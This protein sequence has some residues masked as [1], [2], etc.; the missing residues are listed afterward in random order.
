MNKFTFTLV[1]LT[2]FFS[3]Q[4]SHAA[5]PATPGLSVPGLSSPATNTAPIVPQSPTTSGA[6][7]VVAQATAPVA[8]AASSGPGTAAT[9]G[10]DALSHAEF[11]GA[12]P[13]LGQWQD[14]AERQA[15]NEQSAK[16]NGA[17]NQLA[18]QN[19]QQ[20][21][22]PPVAL[23]ALSLDDPPKR[24][25]RASDSCGDRDGACF[26]AVYGMHV[27]G[28]QDNYHGLLAID[29]LIETVYKGKSFATPHGRYILTSI[30]TRELTYADSHGRPHTVPFS[31]EADEGADPTELKA[32]QKPL[33]SQPMIQ[34]F[35]QR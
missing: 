8:A 23:R 21:A 4:I 24:P 22:T 18:Q 10:A 6:S 2:G 35:P 33:A 11:I 27:D 15:F 5:S 12:R 1:A 25:H 28:G 13:T 16:V 7:A 26:Y 17:P 14:L 29:G 34:S 31:G 19:Q 20:A 3:A 9:T 30:S 32:A